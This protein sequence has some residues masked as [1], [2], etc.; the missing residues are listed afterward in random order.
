MT[1]DTQAV[2][3][4]ASISGKKI[5]AD[6]NG[7]MTTSDGGVLL[8]RELESR[9]GIVDR[10]VES[11]WD[12]IRQRVLQIACGYEDAN[13]SDDLRCDPGMKAACDRLPI[14]GEDLASQPTISRLENDVSRTDLYRV[15]RAFADAFMSPLLKIR[16]T[17]LV[18]LWW[19]IWNEHQIEDL[20]TELLCGILCRRL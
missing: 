11:L 7:G 1:K 13:D 9:I 4:F 16:F 14:T 15:G 10:I 18:E 8:L 6:F 5:G 2:L 19:H 3:S 12:L 17:K 20:P